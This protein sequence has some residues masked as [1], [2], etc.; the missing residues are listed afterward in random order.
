VVAQGAL[1]VGVD[2]G[3]SVRKNVSSRAQRCHANFRPIELPAE[4]CYIA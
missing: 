4:R 1:Q 2:A 3:G